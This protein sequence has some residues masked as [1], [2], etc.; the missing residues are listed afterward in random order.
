MLN[1]LVHFG[2]FL[3]LD[4]KCTG[5]FLASSTGCL[6]FDAKCT[7]TFWAVPTVLW[8]PK[9]TGTFWTVSMGRLQLTCFTFDPK[10]TG[11][12]WAVSPFDTKCTGT[13]WAVST[14]RLTFDPKCTGT[15][16][17]VSTDF[18]G[19]CGYR[20]DSLEKCTGTF[21]VVSTFECSPTHSRNETLVVT[22]W[23]IICRAKGSFC[24]SMSSS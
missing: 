5:T 1:V 3:T 13:F 2:H 16:W 9:C 12:F 14:E 19:I 23:F 11:T 24:S 18:A 8:L 17:V 7:G 15:F 4:P 22:W 6:T 21:L 20:R 10:C